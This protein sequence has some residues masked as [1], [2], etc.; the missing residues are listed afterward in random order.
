MRFPGARLLAPNCTVCDRGSTPAPPQP[1]PKCNCNSEDSFAARPGATAL[2]T[3]PRAASRCG[4]VL[5]GGSGAS[6]APCCPSPH[7]GQRQAASEARARPLPCP[8]PAL[9]CAGPGPSCGEAAA[10]GAVAGRARD[11]W[12]PVPSPLTRRRQT[13]PSLRTSS[14]SSSRSWRTPCWPG[15]RPPRGTSWETRP[16]WRTWR[17]PS[18][19][20]A[21]SRRR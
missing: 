12:P 11:D 15:C 9:V 14:R 3:G 1:P 5:A 13:S 20:P 19:R 2:P 16:W 18:T 17:P 21:R 6:R 7:G 4:H 10:Q 8:L